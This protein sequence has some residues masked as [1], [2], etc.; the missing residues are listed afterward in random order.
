MF[1]NIEIERFRGIRHSQIQGLNRIN[2]FFGKN[3]SGKSSLL[4]AVFIITGLSNPKLP[5]NVNILRNYL[6]LDRSDMMLNFYS[7]DASKPIVIRAENEESRMLSISMMESVKNDVD[8]LNDRNNALSIDVESV[9]GLSLDCQIDDVFFQSSILFSQNNDG[10]LVQNVK[11]DD[12]YTEHLK[13][14]YLTSK[15]DFATSIDGL[16]NVVK[17]KDEQFIV[18]ALRLIEPN[19]VDFVLMKDDVLVDVGLENRIPINLMGDGARKVLSLLTTIYECKNGVV[20]FDE[21]SNGFHYSVMKGVWQCVLSAAVRNNVQVFATTHDID[22]IKG[23]RD[24]SLTNDGYNK[25]VA[26]FKLQRTKDDDLK[27]YH[28]SVDSV[29]YSV[30]QDIEI[31]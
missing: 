26:F 24:A 22:S 6:K 28:Y 21:I 27:A 11:T 13:C 14:K 16:S 9:Y 15:Y 30:N 23:L 20:L 10:G 12:V 17:N 2:L 5:L 1:D 7:L 19:L 18:D 29:D 4:D 25:M 3:N 31:R 8:L